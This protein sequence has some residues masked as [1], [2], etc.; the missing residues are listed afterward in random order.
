MSVFSS[1]IQATAQYFLLRPFIV[2]GTMNFTSKSRYALKI[3]M[4]LAH[5]SHL[6]LVRRNDIAVRQGI[7]TDY[8]DQIMIRLRAGQLV[9]SVR[10]RAGGYRLARN[11][12]DIN[13]WELFSA[14]EDSIYPVECVTDHDEC[15][16]GSQCISRSA[17]GDI[18]GRM[19]HSLASLT[20]GALSA[21][22][23]REYDRQGAVGPV[24]C[25]PGRSSAV[26][27]PVL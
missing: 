21:K 7:P 2:G 24:E 13:L 12:Q 6:P 16:H 8:L 1:L 10:G 18:F 14:V 26:G 25:R 9:E 3:M 19:K 20:L 15:H 4:D 22:H 23:H 27:T 5:H 17:W 11:P